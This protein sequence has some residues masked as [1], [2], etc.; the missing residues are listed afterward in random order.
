MVDFGA[1]RAL[2]VFPEFPVAG[3]AEGAVSAFAFPPSV[4]VAPAEALV[5]VDPEL[6]LP[7]DFEL[8]ALVVLPVL[9]PVDGSFA[10]PADSLSLAEFDAL[11]DFLLLLPDFDSP[12]AGVSPVGGVA[13]AEGS[14]T[15]LFLV[16]LV[17]T[18]VELL[19]SPAVSPLDFVVFDLLPFEAGSPAP[20]ALVGLSVPCAESALFL[21]LLFFAVAELSPAADWLSELVESTVAFFFFLLLLVSLESVCV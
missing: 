8:R 15:A 17:A 14:A 5:R 12:A 21:I 16:P 3:G 4:P 1:V 10:P 9:A 6:A 11:L 7:A 20:E 18:G 19:D 2:V 13:L